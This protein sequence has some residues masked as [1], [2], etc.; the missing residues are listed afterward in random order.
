[1][2]LDVVCVFEAEPFVRREQGEKAERRAAAD[3]D[4]VAAE[5]GDGVVVCWCGV[6]GWGGGVEACYT[7]LVYIFRNSYT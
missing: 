1:V 7:G 3:H 4:L 2:V 5:E 6:V